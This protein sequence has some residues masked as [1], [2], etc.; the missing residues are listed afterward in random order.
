VT[1]D[2]GERTI[3]VSQR[4]LGSDGARTVLANRNCEA[5]VLTNIFYG[6]VEGFVETAVEQTTIV[7][8]LAVVRVPSDGA[9]GDETIELQGGIARFDRPGCLSDVDRDGAA[10]VVLRQGRTIAYGSRFFLDRGTD[11]A[12]LDGPVRLE[13]SADPNGDGDAIAASADAMTF[14]VTR[15]RATLVGNVQVT[16][17]GR[18]SRADRFELDEEEGVAVL[19]GEPAFSRRGGE[20]VRGNR[21]RYDLDTNEVTAV[22]GIFATF[23][24]E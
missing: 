21:L 14:D 4:T 23:T 17:G 12:V 18:E 11:V 10:A 6:P 13:R 2:R 19:I 8:Q 22:G 3:Q 16:S 1:V 7:S 24:L 15:E 9:E 5:G 20:E